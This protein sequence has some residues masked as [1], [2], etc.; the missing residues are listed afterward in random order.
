[1][2]AKVGLTKRQQRA[3]DASVLYARGLRVEAIAEQ[4]G[5]SAVVVKRYLRETKKG[6]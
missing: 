5:V 1:M 4:I 3:Y 2:R 6:S